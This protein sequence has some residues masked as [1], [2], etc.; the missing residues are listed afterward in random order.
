MFAWEGNSYVLWMKRLED[1]RFKSPLPGSE[2][3]AAGSGKA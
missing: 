1:S 2:A 3:V